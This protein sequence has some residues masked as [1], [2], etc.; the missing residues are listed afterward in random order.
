MKSVL[1]KLLFVAAAV[2]LLSFAPSTFADSFVT[3]DGSY[4]FGDNGYGIPPYGGTLNGQPVEF[5][6]VDFAHDIAGG[7]SWL[8][9]VTPV[10]LS[11]SSSV[12]YLAGDTTDG[13]SDYLL[14]A[15]LITANDGDVLPAD[16]SAGPM[17]HLEPDGGLLDPY[18]RQASILSIAAAQLRVADFTGQGWD[19]LTP[20]VNC[21][22]YGQ[23]FLVQTPEPASILLIG[24]GSADFCSLSAA[25]SCCLKSLLIFRRPDREREQSLSFRPF[26]F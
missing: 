24:L 8:A 18:G 16:P 13:V 17:G 5:Y 15:W 1:A 2:I 9:I 4:A 14:F 6:C 20:D 3:V 23:E 25:N 26:R 10:A 21:N 19:I 12:P 7:D 11:G 22:Q